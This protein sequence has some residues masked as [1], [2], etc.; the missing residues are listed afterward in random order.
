MRIGELAKRTGLSRDTLRFYEREGLIASAP[1]PETSNDYRD[2]PEALI[3]QLEMIT[4]ARE[5]GFS[6]RDLAFFTRFLTGNAE[7][8]GDEALEVEDFLT[9]KKAELRHTIAQAQKLLGIIEQTQ[10]A[11][12]RGP[13]EWQSGKTN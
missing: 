12:R 1:S 5:A 9:S 11:L 4:A 10:A 6:I 8:P 13:V 7:E 2:Y 3:G